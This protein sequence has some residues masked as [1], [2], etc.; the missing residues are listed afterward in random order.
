[1]T[2]LLLNYEE[3]EQYLSGLYKKDLIDINE[4][5]KNILDYINSQDVKIDS[6]ERNLNGAE[7]NS[8]LGKDNLI[9]SNNY[10]ISYKGVLL[11][12]L[13]GSMFISPF[14]YLLGLKTG[15]IISLSGMVI[16]SLSS[17]K[18]QIL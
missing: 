3:D 1:M 18:L 5:Q 7:F 6:I 17:Y 4:T 9:I 10:N 15:T 12:G 16:G 8:N 13:I 11:G 2:K 14:G